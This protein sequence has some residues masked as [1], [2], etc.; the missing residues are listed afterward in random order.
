MISMASSRRVVKVR[1]QARCHDSS[2]YY[3]ASRLDVFWLLC[4][5]VDTRSEKTI[6]A[7]TCRRQPIN[8]GQFFAS[9]AS[10]LVEQPFLHPVFSDDGHPAFN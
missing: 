6:H 7:L 1:G 5:C 9:N 3:F 8:I 4:V 10:P 2:G